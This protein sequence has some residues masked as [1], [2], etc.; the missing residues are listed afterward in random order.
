MAPKKQVVSATVLDQATLSGFGVMVPASLSPFAPSLQRPTASEDFVLP[1]SFS[2]F[3]PNKQGPTSSEDFV[4]A[5]R[6]K[7]AI[8]PS[9]APIGVWFDQLTSDEVPPNLCP[10]VSIA[11]SI[12]PNP[13]SLEVRVKARPLTK[14]KTVVLPAT[15]PLKARPTSS[16][17][18]HPSTCAQTDVFCNRPVTLLNA[19]IQEYRILP[20]TQFGSSSK[21]SPV[22]VWMTITPNFFDA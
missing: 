16:V 18:D 9:S 12:A 7:V 6:P 8:S 10:K 11:P 4:A 17:Q 3:A 22:P 5:K 14:H 19:L 15:V 20:Y 13:V 21:D 2:P 1:A